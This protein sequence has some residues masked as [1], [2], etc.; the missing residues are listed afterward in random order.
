M[1]HANLSNLSDLFVNLLYAKGRLT[2]TDAITTA[3]K[4]K[5]TLHASEGEY[6]DDG[7][8]GMGFMDILDLLNS[9]DGKGFNDRANW[10]G[11]WV[12]PDWDVCKAPKGAQVTGTM[13]TLLAQC[14]AVQVAYIP[15]NT[16]WERRDLFAICADAVQDGGND[17]WAELIRGFPRAFVAYQMW[18]QESSEFHDG[19]WWEDFDRIRWVF[20]PGWRNRYRDVPRLGNVTH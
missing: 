11:P 18:K 12:I 4:R 8:L 6:D 13:R 2:I 19:D 1:G 20:A 9:S 14:R 7:M 5:E 10:E 17:A 16:V 15:I 3:A